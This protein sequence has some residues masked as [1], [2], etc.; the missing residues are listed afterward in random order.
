MTL[1]T[2]TPDK[3]RLR[4]PRGRRAEASPPFQ[5]TARDIAIVHQ[6]WRHRFMTAEH[7]AALLSAPVKKIKDRLTHLYHHGYLDRPPA[8]R[9]RHRKATATPYALAQKGARLLR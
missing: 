4:R 5:I 6:V 3:P 9:E 2:V 1:A 8:H 7:I